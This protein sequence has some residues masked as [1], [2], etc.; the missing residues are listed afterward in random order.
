[1]IQTIPRQSFE[2]NAQNGSMNIINC[3]L[4]FWYSPSLAL[5]HR[6]L[7]ILG[8]TETRPTCKNYRFLRIHRLGSAKCAQPCKIT[9]FAYNVGSKCS[10]ACKAYCTS[11]NHVKSLCVHITFVS[12]S[13]N[14]CPIQPVAGAV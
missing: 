14:F 3:A 1:M 5:M 13:F 10:C 12:R 4:R 9:V 11:A 6:L 8:T 7:A 2:S